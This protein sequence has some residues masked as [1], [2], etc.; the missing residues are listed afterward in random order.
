LGRNG[1]FLV[2]RKLEQDVA[3]FWQFVQ[4]KVGDGSPEMLGLASKFIGRWPSGAPVS[5][6]PHHDD[7][8]LGDEDNF[9]FTPQDAQGFR[10][11]IGAHMRRVNP[12]D[13]LQNDS[14]SDSYLTCSRHRIVRRGI[15]YGE[16]LFPLEMTNDGYAPADLQDDGKPRGLHFLALNA[17]ISRQFEFIQQTWCNSTFF[18]AL[19]NDKDPII[20]DNDGT[21]DMTIEE[22]PYRWRIRSLPRFVSVKGSAY[23]FVPAIS[24]LRFMA[25]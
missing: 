14:P 18:Q 19:F 23:L 25:S 16:P 22:T 6:S 4:S 20:G 5:L 17:C 10:C 24:A 12:R 9:G 8:A 2:Y 11:P 21:T 13:S 3:G 1:T 15:D 7:P